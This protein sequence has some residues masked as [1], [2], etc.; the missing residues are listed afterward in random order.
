MQYGSFL[1]LLH[2]YSQQSNI[3][4]KAIP[5]VSIRKK[6]VKFLINYYF[7]I[8]NCGRLQILY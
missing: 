1:T 6:F 8:I 4:E 3:I 7:I 2:I 5:R